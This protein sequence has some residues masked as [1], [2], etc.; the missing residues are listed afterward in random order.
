[1]QEIYIVPDRVQL[2]PA[3]QQAHHRLIG[4]AADKFTRLRPAVAAA[5]S[6]E[7]LTYLA[8]QVSRQLPQPLY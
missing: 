2:T 1:M 5:H 3:I 8:E 4:R 6:D 7:V